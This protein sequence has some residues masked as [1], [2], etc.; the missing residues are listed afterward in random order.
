MLFTGSFFCHS[1][2]VT[3]DLAN[4]EAALAKLQNETQWHWGM[5]RIC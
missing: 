1:F 4:L 2:V 5:C 3:T